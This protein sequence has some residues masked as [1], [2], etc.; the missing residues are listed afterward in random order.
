MKRVESN[1]SVTREI[2][3][4]YSS[5]QFRTKLQMQMFGRDLKKRVHNDASHTFN[6]TQIHILDPQYNKHSNQQ[7]LLMQFGLNNYSTGI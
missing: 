6:F 1:D 5:F 3:Q 2:K 4:H 7:C